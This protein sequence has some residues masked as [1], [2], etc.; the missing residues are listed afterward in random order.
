MKY[1]DACLRRFDGYNK[2]FNV[3][4]YYNCP[5]CQSSDTRDV[6]EG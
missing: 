6:R 5:F 3:L 2:D 1:C 4:T